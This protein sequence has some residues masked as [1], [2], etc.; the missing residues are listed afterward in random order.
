MA[1]ELKNC[2]K[3]SKQQQQQKLLNVNFS[4]CLFS[5][6]PHH[7]RIHLKVEISPCFYY[8]SVFPVSCGCVKSGK[9]MCEYDLSKH[10]LI[11]FFKVTRLDLP[12]LKH[13]F[14]A[15]RMICRLACYRLLS[16]TDFVTHLK[17]RKTN[18]SRCATR[19]ISFQSLL[20]PGEAE[21]TAK[22]IHTFSQQMLTFI[23]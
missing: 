20:R 10:D 23:L 18:T 14:P 11:F 16:Y 3:K 9:E 6:T 5:I 22:V 12:R 13:Y 17:L 1:K 19:Q 8:T 2:F 21:L 7:H 15:V 4:V